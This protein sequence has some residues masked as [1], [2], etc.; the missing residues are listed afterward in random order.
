MPNRFA[1]FGWSIDVAPGW[2]AEIRGASAFGE[3]ASFV[4]IVPETDDALLTLVTDERGIM[5]ASQWAELVGQLNRAKGRPVSFI[6]CGDF[7]GNA[8]E[9]N[10]GSEWIRGWALCCGSFPLHASYR[11]NARTMGRD[12]AFVDNM[13]STLHVEPPSACRS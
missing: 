13:L 8:V 7:S 11:C 9:F 4:V 10:S 6:Q 1:A 12:D 2:K 5:A 3:T